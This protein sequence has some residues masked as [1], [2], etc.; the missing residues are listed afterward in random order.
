[1]GTTSGVQRADA[2]GWHQRSR[3]PTW[4]R[5]LRRPRHFERLRLT[6]PPQDRP[7]LN[8]LHR[9]ANRS[10]RRSAAVGLE[11][12]APLDDMVRRPKVSFRSMNPRSSTHCSGIVEP[13]MIPISPGAIAPAPSRPHWVSPP[14]VIT[15]IPG[16]RPRCAAAS[17]LNDPSTV[18]DDATSGNRWRGSSSEQMRSS[19]HRLSVTSN[20]PL[21]LATE[22]S[23]TIFPDSRYASQ[24]LSAKTACA[25]P[26]SSGTACA[27]HNNREAV[28]S[29]AGKSAPCARRNSRPRLPPTEGRALRR[30]RLASALPA[31][32][33]RTRQRQRTHAACPW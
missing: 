18:P 7:I 16:R 31:T 5:S 11:S 2:G 24:S 3:L 23:T 30:A 22:G 4:T 33:L 9:P 17:L 14:P 25:R 28:N 15:G 13:A 21:A 12:P 8:K 27:I 10:C 19:A 6:R 29:G 26:K 1:M 20:R 32:L